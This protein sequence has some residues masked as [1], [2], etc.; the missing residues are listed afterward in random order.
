MQ[1]NDRSSE[2]NTPGQPPQGEL[3]FRRIVP[4]RGPNIWANSPVLEAWVD[5]GAL[6][7]ASSDELPGFNERLNRWLPGLIEHHCSEGH[8]GGFLE[9]LRRGTYPAHVLEHVTLELMT[10]AGWPVGFGR[11]R[12]THEEGLYRV[13]VRYRDET[14][15]RAC[16]E[17][18][19]Q[20]LNAAYAGRDHDVP[21]A[22]E[23]LRVLAAQVCPDPATARVLEVARDRGV[24]AR[25][26]S[27]RSSLLLLGHGA[28]ARRLDVSAT[29][30][31]AA[32]AESIT[33]DKELTK[34]L[35]APAGVPVP[36]GRPVDSP[37]DAWEAAEDLGLPVVLKP[38][39]CD[40]GEGVSLNLTTREQV[41]AA[42]AIARAESRDILVER[43][44]D[45]PTYRALVVGGR[46]AAVARL[47]PGSGGTGPV[48]TD[49]TDRVHPE[50]ADRC[51]LAARVTGL[52][53]AGIDL[54]TPDIERPLEAVGGAILELNARPRLAPHLSP[55]GA[56]S[57]AIEALVEHLL[58][59]G[60]DG[61]IAT[62]GITGGPGGGQVAARLLARMLSAA[63]R[64]TGLAAAGIVEVD[65]RPLPGPSRSG[66]DATR[67]ILLN[68][69]VQAAVVV[70]TRAEV[71]G[72]G[73]GID[74]L[75]VGVVAGLDTGE[76]PARWGFEDAAD[77]A[78][79][80][81]CLVDIVLPEGFAVLRGDAPRIAAMAEHSR[82][83][84]ILFAPDPAAPALVEHRAA[85]GRIVSRDGGGRAL[86]RSDADGE[87]RTPL[88]ATV[89]ADAALAAVAAAWAL[90]LDDAAIAAGLVGTD[91]IG[92]A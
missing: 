62:V 6:N 5:L 40:N 20:L 36:E 88:P 56:R 32:V 50:V 76:P 82:G 29:D 91:S 2:P 13:I 70:A 68:P 86:V 17:A 58:P 73:L 12:A 38:Q 81:R 7:E 18:G 14:L 79:A 46:V 69:S 9:R 37:A 27:D 71:L 60:D 4:L 26:L 10:L 41:E 92:A 77:L 35:L 49:V 21:A 89:D 59:T 78:R 47:E 84:V 66:P 31:T 25:R 33:G 30:R 52:D 74:R 45:G 48:A 55:A 3:V 54:V 75:R 44:I 72:Q 90:G 19:R 15:A 57:R 80:E 24:P 65:G 67:S 87:R 16:L 1:P 42:Y 64:T 34:E 22:V 61:R 11:A 83:G 85:G 8:R 53:V 43:Q 23:R 39:D 28:A 63:G 51:V